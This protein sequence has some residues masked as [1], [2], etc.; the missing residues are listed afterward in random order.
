MLGLPWFKRSRL[1]TPDLEIETLLLLSHLNAEQSQSHVVNPASSWRRRY[2]VRGAVPQRRSSIRDG[3]YLYDSGR[4]FDKPSASIAIF[5][6]MTSSQS[7]PEA[8]RDYLAPS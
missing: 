8:A 3:L 6:A 7:L 4:A 5:L 2:D 1:M